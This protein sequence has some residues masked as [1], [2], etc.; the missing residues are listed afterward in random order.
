[1]SDYRAITIKRRWAE[2]IVSGEKLYEIRRFTTPYRGPLV[3]TLSGE[4]Q[5]FCIVDLWSIISID[6]IE[7]GIISDEEL[8]YGQWAWELCNPTLCA[9]VPCRGKLGLWRWDAELPALLD[10]TP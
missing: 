2:R 6:H 8:A 5:A 7:P 4:K 9:P 3:I 10:V 1:V